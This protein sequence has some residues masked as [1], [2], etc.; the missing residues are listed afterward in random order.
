MKKNEWQ[1]KI[2]C[3]NTENVLQNIWDLKINYV[4]EKYIIHSKKMYLCTVEMKLDNRSW[5]CNS[6]QAEKTTKEASKIFDHDNFNL[7]WPIFVL[8]YLYIYPNRINQSTILKRE[9]VLIIFQYYL[10]FSLGLSAIC[11][12]S[13]FQFVRKYLLF[14]VIIRRDNLYYAVWLFY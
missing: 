3:W 6:K 7:L 8:L 12:N 13:H 4:R 14:S 9:N 5:K 2:H 1:S 10:L 11:Y